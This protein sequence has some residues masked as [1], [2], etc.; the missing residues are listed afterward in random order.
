VWAQN[1]DKLIND[2]STALS[3]L[4]NNALYL[5]AAAVTGFWFFKNWST[6]TSFLLS[7]AVSAGL[8]ALVSTGSE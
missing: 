4:T 7:S 1:V 6:G 3:L 8:V 2:Q 5:A